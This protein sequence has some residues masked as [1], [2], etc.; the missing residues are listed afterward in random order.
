MWWSPN[1]APRSSRARP[2]PNAR[3]ALSPS[4]TLISA[5]TL[6]ARRSQSPE[7]VSEMTDAVLF[8]AREDGIAV[9]TINR[10]DQRNALTAEVR[11]GLRT[12]W[13]RFEADDA[14]RI[15]ILTGS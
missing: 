12:A 15:A 6:S 3:A 13:Q 10:P 14:L 5:R 2:W 4:P 1:T 9:I 7:G 11:E 8:D